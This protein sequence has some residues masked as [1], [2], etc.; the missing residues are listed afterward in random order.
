M[1]RDWHPRL[2]KCH[3]RTLPSRRVLG[4]ADMQ[5]R[6]FIALLGGATVAWPLAAHAQPPAM[7]VVGYLSSTSAERGRLSAFREGLSEIGFVEG[8]SVA[9]EYRFAENQFDRLPVFAA[10]LVR[11]PVNVLAA[12]GIP[13][14]VAAKA[15]TTTIPI[16]F[17]VAGDPVKLGLVASMNRPGG[18]LT[19]ATSLGAELSAKRLGWRASSPPRRPPLRY[20]LTRTIPTPRPSSGTR[21]RRLGAS[22]CSFRVLRA[23]SPNDID[24]N[25]V[26]L[27]QQQ[28]AV[29]VVGNDGLFASETSRIGALSVHHAVPTIFQTPEFTAAGGLVSYGGSS[30]DAYRQFGVYTGRILKGEKPGDLPVVQSTKI[31]LIVNL[32]TAK[33]L[34][35]TIPLPLLGRADEVIE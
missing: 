5:R 24:A 9:I 6:D 30:T 31:E 15:A 16:A 29:L 1:G 18:N 22:G 25:F 10:E 27:A 13:A 32:K 7:P 17:F 34:G 20:S 11:R 33:T 12:A 23:T 35:L 2:A 21:R 4:F 26:T 28:G 14:S 8:R 3:F 19:G